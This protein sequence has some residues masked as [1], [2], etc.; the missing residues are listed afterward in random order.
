VLVKSDEKAKQVDALVAEAQGALKN[1]EWNACF[2]ALDQITQ[3]DPGAAQRVKPIDVACRDGEASALS[4]KSGRDA[5]TAPRK[6][7]SGRSER[8][9]AQ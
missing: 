8:D 7:D 1:E 4:A 3:L 2:K 6:R 9:A 5:G